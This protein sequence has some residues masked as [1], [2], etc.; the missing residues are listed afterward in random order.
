[1]K[2][3]YLILACVLAL[4]AGCFVVSSLA[5]TETHRVYCQKCGETVVWEPIAYGTTIQ[6]AE[7]ETTVQ[8]HY[9]V[10]ADNSYAGQISVKG[11]ANVCVDLNGKKLTFGGRAFVVNG[12]TAETPASLS[13]QDS[14]GG[15]TVTGTSGTKAGGHTSD[16]NN[17]A[18]GVLYID[19]YTTLNIYGGTYSLD[20]KT[21]DNL[22]TSA[23][24]ILAIYKSGTLN[25]YGG[26]FNGA[27][28]SSRGGAITLEANGT[29]NLYGGQIKAGSATTGKCINMNVNSQKILLSGNAQVDEIYL[30]S[31][32]TNMLELQG[33]FTGKANITYAANVSGIAEGAD[34]G[35]V[36]GNGSIS[37]AAELFCTNGYSVVVDGTALKLAAPK[38][39]DRYVE[40][41]HCKGTV[42]WEPFT[43][44]APSA[45]GT[46]HYY[47]TQDYP[48]GVQY[49]IKGG[50]KVCL[51]LNGHSYT[52]RGRALLLSNAGTEL[53]VIDTVGGGIFHAKGGNNNPFGGVASLN[54]KTTLNLYSGTLQFTHT[55]AN[56]TGYGGTA[57][58][59][60][61]YAGAATINVYGG[62][63]VGG[64]VVDTTYEV[65]GIEGAGG[66]IYA[67]G[68]TLNLQGGEIL[69]GK[70]S[71]AGPGIYLAT[72]STKVTLGGDAKVDDIHFPNLAPSS[73]VVEEGF[74][75]TAGVSFDSAVALYQG[76]TVGVC[77]A[78]DWKGT[79]T[80]ASE[81]F[82]T[83]MPQDDALVISAFP[84]GAVAGV[85]N[86]GFTSLQEAVDAAKEGDLVQ[87]LESVE[88]DITVNKT[89]YLQLNGCNVDGT[90]TIADGCTVY[91]MDSATMDF[92]VAD[93]VYGKI[94]KVV[95][96]YAGAAAGTPHT[97]DSYLAI[98][99]DGAVSFHCVRLQ[100]YAMTL[101]VDATDDKQEPGLFYKSYFKADEKAAALLDAHGVALSLNGEPTAENLEAECCYT[102]FDGFESG[103]LGN[104]GNASSTLLTGILKQSYSDALNQKNAERPIYGRAYALTKDGQYLF[105]NSVS[106]SLAQQLED[107]DGMVPSLSETQ[108][109]A[110]VNTYTKFDHVLS[111]LELPGIA[112]AVETQEEGTLKILVL[113]N[114]HGLD[115][116]NLLYEVFHNE[117]PEQKVVIGALYYSGCTIK[118]HDEY[119]TN[120]TRAYRYYKNDGTNP[121]RTWSV[122]EST[123]LEALE[124]EQWDYIFMQQMNNNAGIDTYYTADAFK[125]SWKAVADYLMNNQD[126]APKLGFHMVWTNP[127]DY[128]LYLNDDAPYKTA[129]S[130]AGWRNNH[131]LY[132]AGEDGKYDQSKLYKDIVRCVQQYLVNDTSLVGRPFDL[133]LPA[134]TAIEYAQDVCGRSQEHIY[135]D[136]T[137]INDYGRLIAAYTWYASIM[138]V[139][140]LTEV[141]TNEIPA[142][143]KY[144]S[145]K[146][147]AANPEGVYEVTEDMKADLMESVN[148]AL[149]NPFSLPAE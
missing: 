130:V 105:G 42:K 122:K 5:T 143:L 138:G 31:K 112:Q 62:K 20:V 36:T 23:G 95:G 147:P 69:A 26:T 141:N 65:T 117:A 101:R 126:V 13:I 96:T 45:A 2:K 73:F 7:G 12:A 52:T 78:T 115:A 51:D 57:R 67:S 28:V 37:D 80:C 111:G 59:G 90:L 123:C 34:I 9:Y 60:V 8:K 33:A 146:F 84:V 98:N 142:V 38:A 19:D 91:G 144:N 97:N 107:V 125:G 6:P 119:L 116:T 49:S 77:N 39:E 92:T 74:T 30:P 106:R 76:L 68:T 104:L 53:S 22:R 113:G 110:L 124:D 27:K 75:G 134:G 89:I 121:N 145:S 85:G 120:N 24:G 132:W 71:A 99:E 63:I 61:I 82:P 81:E 25:M 44:T 118:L 14:V 58:G 66:A 1:M 133:I 79:I 4:L 135:R 129:G 93:G 114:S 35:T 128:E 137:H 149:K 72:A 83:I 94:T 100:I 16:T 15:A 11:G 18:G 41:P 50:V 102:S 29:V 21:P 64:E 48:S 140:E 88:G 43:T 32:N 87:V 103:A 47:L 55:P 40:C 108:V 139:E 54:D 17:I 148:W 86:A 3:R 127:D 56:S 10:T 136:Y 46:Y 131:E 109:S 70:A